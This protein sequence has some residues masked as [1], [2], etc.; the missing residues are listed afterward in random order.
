MANIVKKIKQ[1]PLDSIG[2]LSIQDLEEVIVYTSDKY[3]NS[4]KPVIDDTTYDLLIDYLRLRDPKSNVL[5]NIGAPIKSK[6]K[7]KLDYHLGSMDK[8]KPSNPN[9]NLSK[10]Y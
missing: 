1:N 9:K 4:S 6:N 3:Y 8:I 10:H 2:E 7:V 5:K